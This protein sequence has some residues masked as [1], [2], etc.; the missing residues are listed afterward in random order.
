MLFRII[1]N[2]IPEFTLFPIKRHYYKKLSEKIA[3][4]K[5]RRKEL[6]QEL[7]NQR[8]WEEKVEAHEE[9]LAKRGE[10][11]HIVRPHETITQIAMA[12][13]ISGYDLL[14]FNPY[15]ASAHRDYGNLIYPGD[16]IKLPIRHINA[17]YRNIAHWTA[18]NQNALANMTTHIR[19]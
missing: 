4:E 13:G 14:T 7:K 15:L 12:Y 2:T 1:N 11:V 5:A 18:A 8:K 17:D 3:K 9:R 19:R 6:E 16:V 10:R